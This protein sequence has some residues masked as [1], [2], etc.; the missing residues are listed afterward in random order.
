VD[1]VKTEYSHDTV[2]L[3]PELASELL[4]YRKA[5]Y[6]TEADWLFANPKTNKPYHKDKQALSPGGGSKEA[7]P[8]RCPKEPEQGRTVSIRREEHPDIAAFRKKMEQP[9]PKPS[10]DSADR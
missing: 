1:D 8:T 10:I 9:E 4:K 6:P 2:P 7:Y 3:A 5:S